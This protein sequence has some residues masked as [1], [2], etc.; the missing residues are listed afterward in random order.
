[1][2]ELSILSAQSKLDKTLLNP[3][4]LTLSET[5]PGTSGNADIENQEPIWDHSQNDPH[6]EVGFS[7]CQSRNSIESD[8]EEASHTYL[9]QLNKKTSIDLIFWFAIFESLW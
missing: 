1:M 5:V 3:E 8:P 4:I 9:L 2:T 7:V 6:P